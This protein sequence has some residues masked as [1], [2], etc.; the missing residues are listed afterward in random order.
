M[1]EWLHLVT[2]DIV[3]VIDAMAL[4]VVAVG[5]AEAFFTGLW[6]AFS[7]VS[8]APPVPRDPGALRALARR[9]PHFPGHGQ[10]H[11]DIDEPTWQEVG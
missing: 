6:A 7:R 9:G 2:K 4:I 11:S 10:H 3:V 5:A 8:V 1:E